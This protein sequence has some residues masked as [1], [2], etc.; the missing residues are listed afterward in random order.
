MALQLLEHLTQRKQKDIFLSVYESSIWVSDFMQKGLL[1]Q[2]IT[3]PHCR[4]FQ[5][6]CT[7][8]SM[9]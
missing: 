3:A 5:G 2:Y 4:N 1:G 7:P 8:P 9:K 6:E